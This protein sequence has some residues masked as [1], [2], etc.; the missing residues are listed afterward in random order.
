MALDTYAELHNKVL[1]RA[2]GVSSLLARDWISYAFRQVYEKRAWSWL[3]K[4]GQ[5][6]MPAL[7]NDGTVDL[8]RGSATVVGTGTAFDANMVGRS[9]TSGLQNPVYTIIAVAGPTSLTLDQV[10]GGSTA[11]G[12]RY[13]IFLAYVTVPSDFHS[14]ISVWDPRFNWQLNLDV[15]QEELNRYDAQRANQASSSYAVVNYSYSLDPS[16][17]P[18]LPRYELWP[19]QKQEYVYPFLYEARPPDLEDASASLPR[20]I[21]GDVLLEM[22]LA[23]AARWPGTEGKPNSYHNL[24]LADFHEAKGMMMLLR[25]ELQDDNVYEDDISYQTVINMPYA[26]LPWVDA[27]WMQSHDWA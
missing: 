25:L 21:R 5:F 4:T 7:E 12:Q 22:A 10:W 20:F 16:I 27:N 26:P 17:V 15:T 11:T 6:L 23:E 8:T 13:E 2:P 24:K 19:H 9:L 14:F 18:P 3:I 1:L